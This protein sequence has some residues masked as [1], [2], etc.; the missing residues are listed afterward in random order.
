MEPLTS[1]R[2]LWCHQAHAPSCMKSQK[3]ALHGAPM[4]PMDGMMGQRTAII[5]ATQSISQQQN[6]NVLQTQWNSSTTNPH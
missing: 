6:E 1:I 3:Y 4:T 5:G 2:R